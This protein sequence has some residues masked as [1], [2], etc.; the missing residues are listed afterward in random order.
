MKLCTVK[1]KYEK[2]RDMTTEVFFEVAGAR[3]CGYS[4]IRFDTPEGAGERAVST[5]ARILRG[6]KRR[7]AVQFFVGKDGFEK[8]STEARFLLNVCPECEE[9]SGVACN[10]LFVKI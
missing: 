7:G 10:Y 8:Q 9:A 4:V 3:A 5:L 2:L 6:M 1:L